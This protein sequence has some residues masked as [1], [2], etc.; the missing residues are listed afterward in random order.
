[1]LVLMTAISV[2]NFILVA[3]KGTIQLP[4][5]SSYIDG[6]DIVFFTD[7]EQASKWMIPS[8]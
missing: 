5:I 6:L 3:T 2:P 7:G 4:E 8:R 1:M